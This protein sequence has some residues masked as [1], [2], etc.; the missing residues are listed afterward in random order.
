MSKPGK[1]L[2]AMCKRLGVRLTVKR[3][4]KRVYKSVAV[5]KRQCANKKK[6]KV[7]RIR[8]FGRKRKQKLTKKSFF[9]LISKIMSVITIGTTFYHLINDISKTHWRLKQDRKETQ[10]QIDETIKILE[11]NKNRILMDRVFPFQEQKLFKTREEQDTEQ[12]AT[13][14]VHQY[15]DQRT[16]HSGYDSVQYF[17]DYDKTKQGSL[18]GG[19]TFMTAIPFVYIMEMFRPIVTGCSYFRSDD[20]TISSLI[21]KLGYKNPWKINSFGLLPTMED[22][23]FKEKP[24]YNEGD[25]TQL[26]IN[27]FKKLGIYVSYTIARKV[28]FAIVLSRFHCLNE[29]LKSMLEQVKTMKR[30]K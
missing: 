28:L 8:K 7:K 1:V 20:Y 17:I 6:K 23:E 24:F 22:F 18:L 14:K 3:G 16:V 5:L 27:L 19:L 29:H 26:I 12:K 2:K 25:L 9:N 10:D 11:K 13:S 21:K 15:F 4:K 30:I